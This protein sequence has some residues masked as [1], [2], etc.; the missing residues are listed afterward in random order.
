MTTLLDDDAPTAR[1]HA[2]VV[3][4]GHYP[5]LPGGGGP[6]T[7]R[8]LGLGQLSSPSVSATTF[9]DWL[10]TSLNNPQAPLGS[11]ELLVSP[12]PQAPAPPQPVERA[13]MA[14]VRT[15]FDGW[16]A[17]CNRDAGNVAIFYFCG[18]GAMNRR[19]ALLTEDFG[20]SELR[21]FEHAID[22]EMTQLAMATCRARTQLFIA[23]ACREMQP[24]VLAQLNFDP[25]SLADAALGSVAP[26]DAPRIYATRA[27]AQAFARH[28][29]PTLFMHAFISALD[30][31]GSVY[32]RGTGRWIVPTGRLVTATAS[33]LRTLSARP[34]YPEQT[35][36]GG[37]DFSGQGILHVL[38]EPPLVPVRVSCDPSPASDHAT[39]AMRSLAGGAAGAFTRN[40][41]PGDWTLD[42]PAERYTV[43]A[44]FPPGQYARA[45]GSLWAIPPDGDETRLKVVV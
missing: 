6:Q 25:R 37:G 4:V 24:E 44:T 26:D 31:L 19:V 12:G 28:G 30:G 45:R 43:E 34:G 42:V 39:F 18:H 9:A 40:P 2:F 33:A 41:A 7:P 21:M 38:P 3:G 5:H 10:R 13:T 27:G 20:A 14:N 36:F 17:R 32:E 8:N 15:A 22:F 1:T 16:Y 29:E 11:L 35:C 23:D